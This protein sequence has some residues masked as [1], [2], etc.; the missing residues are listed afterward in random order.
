MLL[1]LMEVTLM[2]VILEEQRRSAALMR[3][4][5][6]ACVGVV[7]MVTLSMLMN[8]MQKV[9]KSTKKLLTILY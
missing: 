5:V 8:V 4:C 6:R 1:P 3:A 7:L 2:I 9:Q